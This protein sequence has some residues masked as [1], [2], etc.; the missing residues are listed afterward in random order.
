M[1]GNDQIIIEYVRRKIDLERATSNYSSCHEDDE[2]YMGLCGRIHK[3]YPL[4]LK[5]AA[6]NWMDKQLLKA[7]PSLKRRAT[8][9]R[10]LRCN[11][12]SELVSEMFT[13]LSTEL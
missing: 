9:C 8:K 11:A 7:A 4:S 12:A 5:H 1:P 6:P 2:G 3:I 13:V 10:S